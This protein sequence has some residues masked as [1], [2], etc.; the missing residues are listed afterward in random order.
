MS[1]SIALEVV[2]DLAK[3]SDIV[4]EKFVPSEFVADIWQ[5]FE[6]TYSSKAMNQNNIN[7]KVFEEI[8]ALCLVKSG[9]MPFYMQAK[10][11]FIPNVN[12]DFIL[13]DEVCPVS[14]SAKVSLRERWK[15]ADLE[16][17]A[18]KYIHRNAKSYVITLN[19]KESAAR[20]CKLNECMGINDFIVAT[21]V[22]FDNLIIKLKSTQFKLSPKID[23][24]TS[25]IVI[26][27]AAAHTR[28]FSSS[29]ISY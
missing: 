6:N 17:V 24:V 28:Y 1:T 15:Q 26:D 21:S 18:L 8:I 10:V 9:L 11:A 20:K 13:Y 22:D 7:G 12:Y 23:V 4:N 3:Y 25:N 27:S 2:N 14:L 29:K 19:E 16:A 5:K